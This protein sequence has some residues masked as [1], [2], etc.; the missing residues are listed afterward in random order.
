MKL[1]SEEKDLEIHLVYFLTRN[2]RTSVVQSTAIK[3]K[4]LLLVEAYAL[5]YDKNFYTI[6]AIRVW[7]V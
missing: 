1:C 7:G 5:N 2:F 3:P 4:L 6:E